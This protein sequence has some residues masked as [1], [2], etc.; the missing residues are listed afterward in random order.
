MIRPEPTCSARATPWRERPNLPLSAASEILCCS[1]SQ[2]YLLARKRRD[3]GGLDFVKLNGRTL[4]TTASVTA[5]LDRAKAYIPDGTRP[6]GSA[7]AR[8]RQRQR[9]AQ[10]TK[11]IAA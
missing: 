5:L 6:R 11:N 7:L 2:L 3:E 4:V 9:S 8:Q 1:T 10:R